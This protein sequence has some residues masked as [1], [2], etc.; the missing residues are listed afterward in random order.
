MPPK[1]N[2]LGWRIAAGALTIILGTSWAQ[3]AVKSSMEAKGY[4]TP[5]I[6]QY[7]GDTQW[8]GII[9][10]GALIAYTAYSWKRITNQT[11]RVTGQIKDKVERKLTREEFRKHR[12]N[13]FGVKTVRATGISPLE[14][15]PDQTG[16]PT[17]PMLPW[18]RYDFSYN[19]EIAARHQYFQSSVMDALAKD[20]QNPNK[21]F[22]MGKLY[23]VETWEPILADSQSEYA[24]RKAEQE[25]WGC[26]EV[27]W[28][29]AESMPLADAAISA[30]GP[31][32]K[33]ISALSRDK[34]TRTLFIEV[35]D[36]FYLITDD[37]GSPEAQE[38]IKMLE[39][40]LARVADRR[41]DPFAKAVLVVSGDSNTKAKMEQKLN[42][43]ARIT[44][45]LNSNSDTILRGD[46]VKILRH[47]Q[48]STPYIQSQG[49]VLDA[50]G[51]TEILG[52]M[53]K[54]ENGLTG[55]LYNTAVVL[56]LPVMKRV[57]ESGLEYP[58]AAEFVE[59]GGNNFTVAD[60]IERLRAFLDHIYANCEVGN[61]NIE[62]D[63]KI[64]L[65]PP[66][67]AT[68]LVK[69]S[70]IELL[71][72]QRDFA[73]QANAFRLALPDLN[74][75]DIPL[76]T[77][78]GNVVCMFRNI[79]LARLIM[80]GHAE[81]NGHNIQV[82]NITPYQRL[83]FD[84]RLCN[85]QRVSNT[86]LVPVEDDYIRGFQA[87]HQMDYASTS[88][89][90]LQTYKDVIEGRNSTGKWQQGLLVGVG[91]CP[92]DYDFLLSPIV[93]THMG[94]QCEQLWYMNKAWEALDTNQRASLKHNAQSG[95]PQAQFAVYM[96]QEL[97]VIY[98][99]LKQ[100]GVSNKRITE[101]TPIE[102]HGPVAKFT[103]DQQIIHGDS[104]AYHA[105]RWQIPDLN[106]SL[107]SIAPTPPS[108]GAFISAGGP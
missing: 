64:N 79:Q 26:G 20:N 28:R 73:E 62:G 105:V 51:E 50:T 83:G 60:A 101:L 11:K 48:Q 7:V 55:I 9:L 1:K 69:Q 85:V 8:A 5:L 58:G 40:R 29:F 88:T 23:G 36:G 104:A 68:D 56:N 106:Q 78:L 57:M 96:C 108:T 39:E 3:N 72:M 33:I 91:F 12:I 43:I 54:S 75:K 100:S 71:R 38:C 21:P 84:E 22:D 4:P 24:R 86:A 90:I 103:E 10:L 53:R 76:P 35:P 95:G 67:A 47:E 80:D 66:Q 14:M 42:Y 107:P 82:N 15:F 2:Y 45:A 31:G 92:Q 77:H 81:L 65:N 44:G 13:S 97:D 74:E 34:P 87:A 19:P 52:S 32:A 18:K 41:G 16:Y 98:A 37:L 25:I 89:V 27:F 61:D 46:A 17:T 6:N 94:F 59:A 63:G 93:P 30:F 102:R 70:L 99:E 49:L